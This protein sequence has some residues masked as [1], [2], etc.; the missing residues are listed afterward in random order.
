LYYISADDPAII[1][2]SR[3]LAAVSS[4]DNLVL[5]LV[6]CIFHGTLLLLGLTESVVT[7]CCGLCVHV[8]SQW[9]NGNRCYHSVHKSSE[10]TST[11]SDFDHL[12]NTYSFVLLYRILCLK[13]L[14]IMMPFLV[15]DVSK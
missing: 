15:H 7:V 9:S 6:D 13:E 5:K 10:M 14:R 2:F 3:S 8:W 12:H 11:H 4:S 1:D